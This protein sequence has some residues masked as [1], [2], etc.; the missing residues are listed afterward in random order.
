MAAFESEE[1]FVVYA[2][3][4]KFHGLMKDIEFKASCII[5][6]LKANT[7]LTEVERTIKIQNMMEYAGYAIGVN[8]DISNMPGY[9]WWKFTVP[10]DKKRIWRVPKSIY[11]IL[12]NEVKKNPKHHGHRC[13][14]QDKTLDMNGAG[15]ERG[16]K[17]HYGWYWIEDEME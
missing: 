5:S 10:Y 17:H 7:E 14:M 9:K 13:I 3:V 2:S 8:Y 1:K 6:N 4:H 16:W 15:K 12:P 11:N